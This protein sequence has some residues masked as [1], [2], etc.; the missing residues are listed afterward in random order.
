M[1]ISELI[2][3]LNDNLTDDQK[4]MDAQ[5]IVDGGS[6]TIT[7]ILVAAVAE[8]EAMI[9]GQPVFASFSTAG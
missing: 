1:K 8:G 2:T 9:E 5:F 4:D 3:A 7:H 6:V